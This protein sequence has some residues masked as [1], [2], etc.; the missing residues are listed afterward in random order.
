MTP[1][2]RAGFTL[3]HS[4]ELTICDLQRLRDR[5]RVI[6]IGELTSLYHGK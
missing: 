2:H 6:A 5:K 1:S 4:R 3:Q